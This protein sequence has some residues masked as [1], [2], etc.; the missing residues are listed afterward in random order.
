[1]RG[2]CLVVM[3]AALM[4]CGGVRAEPPAVPE[5]VQRTT[6][7]PT[8]Q[9]GA[10]GETAFSAED[11]V[12]NAQQLFKEQRFSD[13]AEQ[14]KLAYQNQPNPLFLFN[15]GQAYRKALRPIEAREMYARFVSIAP[16]SPLVPEAKGYVQ[17]LEIWI[18]EHHAKQQAE[19][20]LIEKQSELAEQV[21][22]RE[23]ALQALEKA[24]NPPLYKKPWFWAI[25]SGVVVGGG[26][27]L[28]IGLV[29]STRFQTDG[30]TIEI[31]Y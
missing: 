26:V 19:L 11:H 29:T 9:P 1:M 30:G 15:A 13:A 10:A 31:Q 22:Q 17:T 8:D 20:T 3:I 2:R 21:R 4:V 23:V 18:A 24:K 5:S 28:A 14:L 16:D 7:Q 25:V 6:P 27:A 12:K